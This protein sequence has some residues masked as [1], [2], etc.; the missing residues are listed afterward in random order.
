[1]GALPKQ[2]ITRHRQGN[3]RRNHVLATVKLVTCPNCGDWMRS[4]HVCM[5]CGTYRGRQVIQIEERRRE[6]E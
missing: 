3:R 1:M 2:R 6:A 4:H 5:T